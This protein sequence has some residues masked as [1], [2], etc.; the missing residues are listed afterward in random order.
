NMGT[1][2]MSRLGGAGQWLTN[3]FNSGRSW[4]DA[5][6]QWLSSWTS[7]I[8]GN[9]TN[10]LNL[11]G[12][13]MLGNFTSIFGGRFGQWLQQKGPDLINSFANRMGDRAAS[14]LYDRISGRAQGLLQRSF[15]NRFRNLFN[16]GFA[17]FLIGL[18]QRR[19]V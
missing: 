19:Q 2:F 6:R 10:F 18:L 17:Q 11:R 15:G 14:W 9:I 4:L 12:S 5:G 16:S 1:N 7:G 13:R 8:G 3:G